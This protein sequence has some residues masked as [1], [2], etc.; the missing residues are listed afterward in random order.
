MLTTHRPLCP[1][2][3]LT[4]NNFGVARYCLALLV[5]F[6]HCFPLTGGF[7]R[8]D[9]LQQA[10]GGKLDFGAAAVNFFFAISGFL[11]TRS[12]LS[13]ASASDYLRK[14]ILRIYPGFL[15]AFTF[16]FVLATISAGDKAGDYAARPV[17]DN[18]TLLAHVMLIQ[19]N[20]LNAGEAFPSNPLPHRVNEPLWTLHFEMVCYLAVAM[21][22]VC[23]LYGSRWSCLGWLA[24]TYAVY[25]GNVFALEGAD[26]TYWRF[27]TWFLVG[28]AVYHWRERIPHSNVLAVVAVLALAVLAWHP[29]IGLALMPLTGSYLLFFLVFHP[30]IPLHG[31]FRSV[32]LSYGIYL[33]SFPLQQTL[34]WLLE[35]RD[36]TSLLLAAVP[37]AHLAAFASW[38]FVERPFLRLKAK[39]A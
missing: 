28:A 31:L 39:R 1:D 29:P 18:S 13:S 34:V 37:A 4:R 17:R 36:P 38:Y 6:S 25:V 15:V 10:T 20:G 22:G 30:R 14:R 35:I 3:S 21:L 27:L 9:P 16:S 32:D 8:P 24:L 26:L 5:V 2:E 7:E 11:V 23:G 12:W 19:F 33:Y